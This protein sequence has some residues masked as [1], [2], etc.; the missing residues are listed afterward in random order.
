MSGAHA[1]SLFTIFKN[2]KIRFFHL[3]PLHLVTK[4]GIAADIGYCH[5][6]VKLV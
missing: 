4:S 2:P 6:I 1:D 3:L 5:I